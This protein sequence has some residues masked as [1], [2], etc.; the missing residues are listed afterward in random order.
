MERS[1][2]ELAHTEKAAENARDDA[3]RAWR[4]AWWQTTM[5]LAEAE[6]AS[7]AYDTLEDLLRQSRDHLKHRRATGLAMQVV[8]DTLQPT[9][10][11]E[12]VRNGHGPID[13]VAAER[14]L[15]A[16]D[17]GFTKL[18]F[19]RSLPE[20]PQPRRGLPE[21]VNLSEQA[22][23][24]REFTSSPGLGEDVVGAPTYVDDPVLTPPAPASFQMP[25]IIPDGDWLRVANVE[26]N[27]ARLSLGFL[28][29]RVWEQLTE[30]ER[31]DV[32]RQLHEL[33]R[34][35]N[36]VGGASFIQEVNRVLDSPFSG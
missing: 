12:F 34:L 14:I 25:D 4:A 17:A 2:I 6:D 36:E 8:N 24:R 11:V 5:A 3:D 23:S 32:V 35:I 7:E 16:E 22:D 33:S 28:R 30:T 10:A 20:R 9:F 31:Y 13:E 26:L 15:S 1:L 18:E 29:D 19:L 21:P 27:K